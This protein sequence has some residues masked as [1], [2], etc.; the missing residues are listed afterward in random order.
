MLSMDGKQHRR[1]RGLVQPSFVPAKAQWWIN[2]WIER[3]VHS[4]ID[5][6]VDDGKAELTAIAS[7]VNADGQAAMPHLLRVIFPL[8]QRSIT[9]S[10]DDVKINGSV[11]CSFT[12][13]DQAEIHRR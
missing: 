5:S 1:Y 7:E 10:Y 12:L 3:T 8:E 4:L 6:F 2:I 9:I 13:P 11:D